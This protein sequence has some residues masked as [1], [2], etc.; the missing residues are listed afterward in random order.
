MDRAPRPDLGLSKLMPLPA[1]VRWLQTWDNPKAQPFRIGRSEERLVAQW[2]GFATLSSTRDGK[3][4]EFEVEPGCDR[5]WAEKLRNGP[6][7]ALVR[8]LSG[9][10]TLHASAVAL[11]TNAVLFFGESGSGKSTLAA[12]LCTCAGAEMLGDDTAS[13]TL[14]GG[15]INVS[16]T[17][18][19]HWL[20][21]NGGPNHRGQPQ[22]LKKIP[23]RAVRLAE[24]SVRLCA[25][26]HLAFDQLTSRCTLARTA[27]GQAFTLLSCSL[28]RFV[29]DEPEQWARDLGRLAQ[30]TAAS[31][32]FELRR[33]RDIAALRESRSLVVEMIRAASAT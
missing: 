18:C 24:Q 19:D 28:F 26:I 12:D 23:I 33:P 22:P 6:A 16:V 30:L 3:Q 31:P 14:E 1:N 29:I 25:M 13:L 20:V 15:S 7:A 4:V 11:G 10:L 2:C 5:A 27:G 32:V 8:H 17:E 21:P 9:G